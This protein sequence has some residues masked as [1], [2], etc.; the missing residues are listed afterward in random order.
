MYECTKQSRIKSDFENW[1]KF[2]SNKQHTQNQIK[3]HNIFNMSQL[4]HTYRN[5][6][7]IR[8]IREKIEIERETHNKRNLTNMKS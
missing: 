3:Q 2:N 8:K 6:N 5:F 4:H 1:I 7:R